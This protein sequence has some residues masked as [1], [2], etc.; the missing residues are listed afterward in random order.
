MYVIFLDVFLWSEYLQ[1]NIHTYVPRYPAR[2]IIR[3]DVKN[4]CL[5][6]GLNYTYRFAGNFH[7]RWQS[8]NHPT[9]PA[10]AIG[11]PLA[12]KGKKTKK[13]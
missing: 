4:F 6:G 2:T 12:R 7:C 13:G 1:S 11:K 3:E 5:G 9:I 8:A 10:I